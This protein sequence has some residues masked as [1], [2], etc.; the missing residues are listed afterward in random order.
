MDWMTFIALIIEHLAWPVTSLIILHYL[1]KNIPH[2]RKFIK[3]VTYKD[4]TVEF[5]EILEEVRNEVETIGLPKGKRKKSQP[6]KNLEAI[7][8]VDPALAIIEIWRQFEMSLISILQHEGHVRF[9]SPMKFIEFLEKEGKFTKTERLLYRNLRELRNL[10]V[11]TNDCP[12][13]SKAEVLDYKSFV[14]TLIHRI[15]DIE[16]PLKNFKLPKSRR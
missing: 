12:K 11:H 8:E 9:L 10:A 5:K 13:I 4:V 3:T 15:R 6:I 7:T 1:V 2:L 14:D 16:D